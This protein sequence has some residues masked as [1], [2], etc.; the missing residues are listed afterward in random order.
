MH[1]WWRT[2]ALVP[3]VYSPRSSGR[4]RSSSSRR[5][6]AGSCSTAARR[7]DDRAARRAARHRGWRSYERQ[8]AA[9]E[10][11]GVT[12]SFGGLR[13]VDHLDMQVSEGEIVS[14]IGP[15]GAGKTTVFNLVTGIYE[16]R[17]GRDPL[18]GREHRRSRAAQDHAAGHRAHVPDAA[19]LPEHERQGE[20]DGGGV[21][22]HEVEC[23]RGCAAAAAG[24]ARGA[25]DRADGRGEARVLRR[26]AHGLPARP[27]RVLAVV[28][29]PAAARDRARDG[30]ER[31]AAAARRAGGGDEP[32]G[33]P[34][35]DGAHRAAAHGR[36]HG[37]GH[38]ARHARRRG[39]LGSRRRARPRREDRRGLVRG[40]LHERAGDRG[41]LG[42]QATATK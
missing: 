15:N 36:L 6:P 33:D 22:A 16:A 20:R 13:V 35:A 27:A 8:E 11:K 39:H 42:L 2:A 29:K 26:P 14:L 10:L 28:R 38:R 23:L 41:L 30:H 3:T 34:G 32:E 5:S 4:P 37:D 31:A 12:K 17:L 1:G 24:A 7:V 21:R 40:V 19:A 25:R 18:R 9:F